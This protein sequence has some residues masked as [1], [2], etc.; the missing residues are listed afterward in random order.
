MAPAATRRSRDLPDRGH[1]AES[2]C[3]L[4]RGSQKLIVRL[5]PTFSRTF[6]DLEQIRKK[7]TAASSC[8]E[9]G[10][11]AMLCRCAHEMA[12]AGRDDLLP[13]LRYDGGTNDAEKWT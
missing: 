4:K 11:D 6:F 10:A 2:V 12:D 8:G 13:S 9:S 5:Y 3:A 7:K 1:G